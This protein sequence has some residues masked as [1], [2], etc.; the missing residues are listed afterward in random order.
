MANVISSHT[1]YMLK[2]PA[3]SANE[4]KDGESY[5][6]EAWTLST[7][8]NTI[9]QTEWFSTDLLNLDDDGT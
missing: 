8:G 7:N 2:T 9:K 5:A 3:L 4:F 1:L 6:S